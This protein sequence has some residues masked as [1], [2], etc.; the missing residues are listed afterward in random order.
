MRAMQL[1]AFGHALHAASA[2]SRPQCGLHRTSAVLRQPFR[3][4]RPSRSISLACKAQ[5]Q[6]TASVTATPP[7]ACP[8]H[9][10]HDVLSVDLRSWH[11]VSVIQLQ[12]W[13]RSR[14]PAPLRRS[15]QATTVLHCITACMHLERILTSHCMAASAGSTRCS[16]INLMHG[17]QTWRCRHWQS[18]GSAW[19]PRRSTRLTTRHSVGS[20]GTGSSTLTRRLRSWSQLSGGGGSSGAFEKAALHPAVSQQA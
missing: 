4:C 8:I 20:C 15:R 12:A 10:L 1:Q 16:I 17:M 19:Q 6:A 11:T 9:L 2:C 3:Q 7:G 5:Q 13:R 18:S 14:G